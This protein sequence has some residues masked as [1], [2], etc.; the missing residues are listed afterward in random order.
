[1]C[2]DLC[3]AFEHIGFSTPVG[4]FILGLGHS[5]GLMPH[6]LSHLCSASVFISSMGGC[7]SEDNE[8]S[9]LCFLCWGWIFPAASSVPFKV[10]ISTQ[11]TRLKEEMLRK[12]T[13][14]R[15]DDSSAGYNCRDIGWKIIWRPA[16][17]GSHQ[18]TTPQRGAAN[19]YWNPCKI[20]CFDSTQRN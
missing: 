3:G 13:I 8:S 6:L 16:F 2:P 1:M 9:H 10:R 14:F 20:L 4:V 19:F 11:E 18:N 17:K 15:K 7:E 12:H 5:L